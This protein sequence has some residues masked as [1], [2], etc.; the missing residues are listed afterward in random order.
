MK[1]F[2][3]QAGRWALIGALTALPL[4][5]CGGQDGDA[6]T[7]QEGQAAP[8]Q[9]LTAEAQALVAQGNEA[10]RDGRYTEALD[11]F[12]KAMEIHPNHPVPQF[13]SL[14]AAMALGDTVLAASLREK[15]AV[16]GPELLAMVSPGSGMGSMAPGT[17]H[18]PGRDAARA[19]GRRQPTS[20]YPSNQ[21]RRK[22][23]GSHCRYPPIGPGASRARHTFCSGKEPRGRRSY[24]RPLVVPPLTALLAIPWSGE[25]AS[26][27]RETKLYYSN[28]MPASINSPL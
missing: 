10:Q 6:A 26:V 13:G 8:S 5:A 17:E 20:R 22:R 1:G 19:P 7:T 24:R 21:T 25:P 15:L 9:P 27:T 12:E 3:S 14:L 28:H 18:I 2:G 23:L 11:L 4:L 16:T